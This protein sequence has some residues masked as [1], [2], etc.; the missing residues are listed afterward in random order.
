MINPDNTVFN[1]TEEFP[2]TIPVFVSQGLPLVASEEKRRTLGRAVSLRTALKMKRMNL[3]A[4]V[5]LLE[6]AV[7]QEKSQTDALLGGSGGADTAVS[8]RA[9]TGAAAGGLEQM[10]GAAEGGLS[11]AGVLPCPVRLPLL[12]K[13]NSFLQKRR[14]EGL[15]E[16]S[17]ELKAASMGLDWL[18]QIID[19]AESSAQL[20][21]LFISAGFDMFFD[22]KRMGRYR[23]ENIFA[24]FSGFEN[25]NPAFA[26]LGLRDPDRQY[27]VIAVVP[28]LFLVN[29]EELGD[30]PV[31]RKWE[32]ILHHRF[33]SSLSLP[34]GDF[35]LFNALLLNLYKKFGD[36]GIQALGRN[37][38]THMHPSQMVRS[39][40]LKENKPAVTI[41]PRFFTRMVRPGSGMKAVW[42][43]DGSIISPI[44]MLTRASEKDGVKPLAEF[45]ASREVGEIL[46]EQGLFPSAHPEVDNRLEPG[47]TFQWIGWDY[48]AQNDISHVIDRCRLVFE[49]VSR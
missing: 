11:V 46:A 18:Q 17:C 15:P 4:F 32:D 48:I 1:I 23:R 14:E 26:G 19:R 40:R 43:E 38:L 22:E 21:S 25:D 49:G 44:F 12:E 33:T 41:M 29:M 9:D 31:P 47:N 7:K 39:G 35:D 30:R 34:V 3:D 8:C 27:S 28:A 36:E 2:E 20:P 16:V 42:P 5:R 37:L 6:E 13:W 10:S 24:D 45:F